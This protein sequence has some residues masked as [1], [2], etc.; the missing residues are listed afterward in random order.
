MK[1]TYIISLKHGSK[2]TNI[3]A[4]VL[5]YYL[6]GSVRMSNGVNGQVLSIWRVN[7]KSF[8]FRRMHAMYA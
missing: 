7:S 2:C 6:D 3:A 8:R 5:V 4:T 1:T